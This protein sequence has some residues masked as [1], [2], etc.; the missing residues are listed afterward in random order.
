MSDDPADTPEAHRARET[1]FVA[2]P[3]C[4]H[5]LE[6][7]HRKGCRIV[8]CVCRQNWTVREIE[9]LRRRY[10]LVGRWYD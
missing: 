1:G 3:A 10:G 6:Y 4:G 8:A 5:N 7:L 9:A 2:C